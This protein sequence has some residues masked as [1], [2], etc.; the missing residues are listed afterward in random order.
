MG[1]SSGFAVNA[2]TPIRSCISQLSKTAPAVNVARAG[3]APTMIEQE[4][5]QQLEVVG[6]IAALGA[7]IYSAR[8][9]FAGGA[10]VIL[11]FLNGDPD[12]RDA[13][14]ANE[15][16]LLK[17]IALSITPSAWKKAYQGDND[18]ERADGEAPEVKLLDLP[19]WQG[20]EAKAL[21]E[22]EAVTR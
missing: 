14:G 7:L 10:A 6:G 11:L 4:L 5:L 19:D 13:S 9:S 17:K 20:D 1:L 8:T 22:P 12:E 2:P 16:E 3:T 21:V 18:V 15:N